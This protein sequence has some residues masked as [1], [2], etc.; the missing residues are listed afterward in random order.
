MQPYSKHWYQN[1]VYNYRFSNLLITL[2][3]VVLIGLLPTCT[4]PNLLCKSLVS[5]CFF[6][7]NFYLFYHTKISAFKTSKLAKKKKVMHNKKKIAKKGNVALFTSQTLVE[8]KTTR[9]F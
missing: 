6:P 8:K 3:L 7:P 2:L 9:I 5:F 1:D 4:N